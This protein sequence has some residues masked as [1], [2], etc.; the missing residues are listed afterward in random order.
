VPVILAAMDGANELALNW[1]RAAVDSI[2]ERQLAASRKLPVAPLERFLQDTRHHP[3]A[4][5]LAYELIA[6]AD[7]ATAQRLIAG[8]LN[9]PST[10]LRRDA[11]QRVADEATKL[12]AAGRTNEAVP[13]FQ[14]ALN[15]ARSVDQ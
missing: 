12:R 8:M 5:R 13:K 9:D 11:V 7:P 10:E 14:T 15:A 2:A 3:R 6:R 1:L 4:R